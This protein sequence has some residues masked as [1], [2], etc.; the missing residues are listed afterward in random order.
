MPS[1]KL[2]TKIITQNWDPNGN[3][4]RIPP[5]GGGTP[6]TSRRSACEDLGRT[7]PALPPL[8]R[9]EDQ[10]FGDFGG[11]NQ[12][13]QWLHPGRVTAS[14]CPHGGLVQIIFFLSTWVICR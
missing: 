8:R 12:F 11:V 7:F 14:T 5:P 4:Y 3:V 9:A 13:S 10:D 1:F 6:D 2:M